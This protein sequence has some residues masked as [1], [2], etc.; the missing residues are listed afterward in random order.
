MASVSSVS[1]LSNL[2]LTESKNTT[3]P[4]FKTGHR[5]P[6][7]AL[8]CFTAVCLAV[9]LNGLRIPSVGLDL[10]Q[11]IEVSLDVASTLHSS[12]AP[13]ERRGTS[14]G[15]SNTSA[16]RHPSKRALTFNQAVQKGSG[17][18]CRMTAADVRNPAYPPQSQF[19]DFADLQDNGW[20]STS[21]PLTMHGSIPELQAALDLFFPP[22]LHPGSIT[23]RNDLHDMVYH[24]SEGQNTQVY[25]I[26]KLVSV[27]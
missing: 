21:Y 14:L 25:L 19:V 20:S 15:I 22:P 10:P 5:V 23:P 27:N 18:I 1:W 12:G 24:N 3:H 8:L 11:Y 13:I 9:L 16:S 6:R 26:F 2:Y 17:Y 4:Y 7:I